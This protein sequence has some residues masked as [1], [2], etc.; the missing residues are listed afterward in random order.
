MPSFSD[1][2]DAERTLLVKRKRLTRPIGRKGSTLEYAPVEE[3]KTPE[4]VE[5]SQDTPRHSEAFLPGEV[6]TDEQEALDTADVDVDDL[7]SQQT[8]RL[9]TPAIDVAETLKMVG[10]HPA[11][12]V[13]KDQYVLPDTPIDQADTLELAGVQHAQTPRSVAFIDQADTLAIP[14]TSHIDMLTTG[15]L[16]TPPGRARVFDFSWDNVSIAEQTT[17]LLPVI[18]LPPQEQVQESGEA[19]EKNYLSN[20]RSLLKSS[21][22]Y[23][24]A[25]FVSPLVALILTPYLAHSLTE[26]EYSALAVLIT[27][28]SLVTGLTQLGLGSAFFR[29]YNYEYDAREDRL[30]ILSVTTFLLCLTVFPTTAALAIGSPALATFFLK[31]PSFSDAFKL[32]ALIILIQNLTIPGFSWLRAD[33]RAAAYSILSVLNVLTTLGATIV[34][35][36]HLHMGIIGAL[37]AT[38]SGYT[39]VVVST[40]PLILVRTKLTFRMDIARGLLSFGIPNVAS[41]ISVWILQ[42]SDRSLL[43]LFGSLDQVGSYSVAYTLGGVLSTVV[44]TPFML[45]WPTTMFSIAK[46][47]DAPRMFQTIFR[48]FACFIL[49]AAYGL[50]FVSTALLALLFHPSYYAAAPIIPLV[51][52]SVVFDGVYLMF[53]TGASIRRKPWFGVLFTAGS[54]LTNVL[55]NVVLIPHYGSLGAGLATLLAYVF[56][57]IIAYFVIQRIYPIPFQIGIFTVGLLLGAVLYVTT[58]LLVLTQERFQGW[59]IEF[60]SL[61]LYGGCLLLLAL[62]P[63]WD[64]KRRQRAQDRKDIT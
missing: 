26:R 50:S 22:I 18:K 54:A 58:S 3:K 51:A 25:S 56:M 42:L 7:A 52:L 12:L 47:D 2:S 34:L 48:W 64:K 4:V 37:L 36:G 49:L 29:L 17:W 59:T 23:T 19:G 62:A 16:V 61:C 55:L 1:E 44:I 45:A 38:A 43:V 41:L 5:T 30:A 27:V 60:V 10:Q 11:S 6:S 21:G 53:T 13:Q 31:D 8:T 57:A 15:S 39:L 32:A 40:L 9:E 35:V 14:G 20:V 33:D 24:L 28:I 46:R 63:S